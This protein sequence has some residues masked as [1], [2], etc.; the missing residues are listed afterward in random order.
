MVKDM[1][2]QVRLWQV[3]KADAPVY[4]TII[5]LHRRLVKAS[6]TPI[7]CNLIQSCQMKIRH[8]TNCRHDD[9]RTDSLMREPNNTHAYSHIILAP[10]MRRGKLDHMLHLLVFRQTRQSIA[11]LQL[12]T[13]N[14]NPSSGCLIASMIAALPATFPEPR[15]DLPGCTS[16][17]RAPGQADLAW[18]RASASRSRIP[19]TVRFQ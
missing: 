7:K 4:L 16:W 8:V 3:Q 12:T 14:G 19:D 10:V 15:S 13:A 1:A 5:S 17:L 2:K 11:R 9:F 6:I 18:T